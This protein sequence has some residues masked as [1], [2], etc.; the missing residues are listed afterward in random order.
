MLKAVPQLRIVVGSMLAALPSMLYLGLLIVLVFYIYAVVGVLLF[1]ANDPRYF[2]SLGQAFLSLFRV[3]TADHWS[4]IMYVNINGCTHEYDTHNAHYCKDPEAF[5]A[6]AGLYFLSFVLL[7]GLVLF[8]LMVAAITCTMDSVAVDVASQHRQEEDAAE[9]QEDP[10]KAALNPE[11]SRAA[12][13]HKEV[14]LL[15]R[16]LEDKIEQQTRDVMSLQNELDS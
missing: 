12:E 9:K 7:A 10:S 2:S 13:R 3:M 11:Q 5:G 8:N 4:E 16:E 15:L 1:K 6:L 14:V